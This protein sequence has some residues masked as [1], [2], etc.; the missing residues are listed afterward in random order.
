MKL[1]DAILAGCKLSKPIKHHL[2]YK[3]GD[4]Y[5][6][7]CVIGA[8][9]LGAGVN[10]PEKIEAVKSDHCTFPELLEAN[11][12]DKAFTAFTAYYAHKKYSIIA[13]NDTYNI[14]REH[15]A[16]DLANLGY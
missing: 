4:T 1:S 6:C 9:L 2:F 14:S 7:C 5:D 16:E 3:E 13:A 15:I 11:G 8:A 10:T 12:V